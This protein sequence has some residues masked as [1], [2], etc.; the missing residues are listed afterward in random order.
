MVSNPAIKRSI[1]SNKFLYYWIWNVAEAAFI[2]GLAGRANIIN[3][4][5]VFPC[6]IEKVTVPLPFD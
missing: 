6:G 4:N 1:F 2:G 3:I 5:E